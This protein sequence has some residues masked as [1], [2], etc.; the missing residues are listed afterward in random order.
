ME[1]NRPVDIHAREETF[2]TPTG[3]VI[4]WSESHGH[5][6]HRRGEY[7]GFCE[8]PRRVPVSEGDAATRV[9]ELGLGSR[10]AAN[11]ILTGP[12]RTTWVEAVQEWLASGPREPEIRLPLYPVD[13]GR[14]LRRPGWFT[15]VRPARRR[16]NAPRG[17]ATRSQPGRRRSHHHL[18]TDIGLRPGAPIRAARD[19]LVVYSDNGVGGYG[20]LIMTV[21]SDGTTAMYAHCRAVY[22]AAGDFILRGE[23]IAEMGDTGIARGAHLHFELR[24]DGQA[25][26]PWEEFQDRPGA[27]PFEVPE[28][29]GEAQDQTAT[30]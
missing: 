12:P 21:H 4:R 14:L 11:V 9:T 8:G 23:T 2:T 22:V 13:D 18:G 26:D 29:E 27:E 5:E 30:P 17:Q 24:R 15:K 20:N 1:R 16:A 19:A 28:F 6:C 25:F 7:R 10:P 3:R